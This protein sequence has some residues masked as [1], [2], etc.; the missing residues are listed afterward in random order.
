MTFS[1]RVSLPIAL[2]AVTMSA[3]AS[4]PINIV[5]GVGRNQTAVKLLKQAEEQ[6]KN[7]AFDDARRSADA[8]LRSDP[9][10]WPALYSRA[11]AYF[12]MGKCE[13][14]LR[15]C[16]EALRQ[17]R[18]FIEA[19]LLRAGANARLGKYA[20]AL[21]E[22]DH[23]ISI[24]P[25][26]DA[27]ARALS[28]RARIRATCRDPMFRDGQ[29][30]VKDAVKACKLMQWKDEISIEVLAMAYAE[31]GDFTSAIHYAEQA[32][33]TKGVSSEHSKKIQRHVELFKQ[34]KPLRSS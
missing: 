11:K 16:N 17:N 33:A 14:A 29:A 2:M 5:A 13:L 25:R 7:G 27:Y 8:S 10:F 20:E 28:D 4:V 19:S 3:W 12:Y 1:G 6:V 9:T 22:I 21:K 24:H 32:L 34:H 15:D 26:T 18:T 31:A 23:C 30:A